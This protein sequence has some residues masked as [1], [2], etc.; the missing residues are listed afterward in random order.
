MIFQS[1]ALG[2]ALGVLE[3]PVARALVLVSI[4][5]RWHALALVTANP[6]V[7]QAPVL[8]SCICAPLPALGVTE[9]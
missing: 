6:A 4:S 3:I 1:R 5:P 8:H 9:A 7:F 2:V